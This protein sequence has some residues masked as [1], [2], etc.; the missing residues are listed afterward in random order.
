MAAWEVLGGPAGQLTPLALADWAGFE[1]AISVNSTGP[2]FQVVALD[3]AGNR[4][5]SSEV[6]A[7]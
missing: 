7:A 1:T 2:H 4:I 6:L 3:G 5:G